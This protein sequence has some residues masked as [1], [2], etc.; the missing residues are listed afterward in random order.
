MKTLLTILVILVTTISMAQDVRFATSINSLVVNEKGTF[1]LGINREYQM[2]LMYFRGGLNLFVAEQFDAEVNA[3]VGF[4]KHSAF[5]KWRYY[6]G[7]Y[8]TIMFRQ[9]NPYKSIG[10]EIG[11]DKYFDSFFIGVYG[12]YVYSDLPLF[13]YKDMDMVAQLGIRIGI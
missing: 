13:Y 2:N 5:N 10:G 12:N 4:N 6:T 9:G 7:L 8:T 3:S 11:I 1:N